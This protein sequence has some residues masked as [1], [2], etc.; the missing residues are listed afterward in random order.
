MLSVVP[1]C[2]DDTLPFLSVTHVNYRP[3][4]QLVKFPSCASPT[5]GQFGHRSGR[6]TIVVVFLLNT[7]LGK[8][9]VLIQSVPST[10]M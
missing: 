2:S 1:V 7:I 10:Y 4:C 9:E 5:V 6:G 3:I 8:S